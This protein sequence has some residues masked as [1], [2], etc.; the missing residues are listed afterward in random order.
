MQ[1]KDAAARLGITQRM[2]RHYEAEGLMQVAR[3]TNGYRSYS[4]SD[5]R[6]AAR[7]RDFI[8]TGFSTREIHAMRAC[9]SDDGSGPCSGGIEKLTE[10]LAHIDRLQA[11]L[12][13][14]R[15]AVLQRL[16]TLRQGLDATAAE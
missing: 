10:K 11:E 6:R 5:L 9:L 13:A 8:A 2:L 4:P 15:T 16:Y 14:K 3:G 7:I 12:D 1:S